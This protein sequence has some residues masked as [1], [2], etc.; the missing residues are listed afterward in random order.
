MF[1]VFIVLIFPLYRDDVVIPFSSTVNDYLE[2]EIVPKFYLTVFSL[3][4][5]YFA[6][7]Q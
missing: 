2:W 7:K 3:Y 5:E 4:V 6:I 1:L